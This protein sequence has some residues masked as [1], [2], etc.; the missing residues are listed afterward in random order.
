[1]LLL[2]DYEILRVICW[3][4]LG[5]LLI[6]FAIIGCFDLGVGMLLPF[7]GK[8]DDERGLIVRTTCSFRW[9][10]QIFLLLAGAV[11][12]AAWPIAFS[13][14]IHSLNIVLYWLIFALLLRPLGFV[15]R[16]KLP[17]K[18]IR[19]YLDKVLF[20]GSLLTVFVFGIAVGN[21]L[22][23]IPFYLESSMN[24]VYVAGT[25]YLFSPFSLLAGI[26][27]VSMIV[28]HSAVYLQLKM[29]GVVSKRISKVVFLSALITLALFAVAGYWII[30][31]EGYHLLSEVFP[32]ADS[33]PLASEVKSEAGL[34]M[35]NYGHLPELWSVPAAVFA[36]GLI[37][38]IL[39]RVN[40]RKSAFVFSSFTI[41]AIILTAVCS[42]FPFMI[43]S[44]ISL[45]SSL[46][47]W[48]SSASIDTLNTVFWCGVF[49]LPL[50]ALYLNYFFRGLSSQMDKSEGCL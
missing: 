19:C 29:Q 20:I 39:V 15:F 9:G 45:S 35:D 38:I 46:T 10:G 22:I 50:I 34:W 31:L 13:V 4:F 42:M 28:M 49:S 1:M 40:R 5:F 24:M 3:A 12:Y 37:T 18:K 27:A 41:A 6:S 14:S 26:L 16:N 11:L 25:Q 33:N 32:N 7:L 48:D 2:F 21:L 43:P 36:S 8:S 44:S 30:D 23:G 47:V 17:G